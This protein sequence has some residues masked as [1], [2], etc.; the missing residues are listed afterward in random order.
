MSVP[1][2]ILHLSEDLSLVRRP[3][4]GERLSYDPRRRLLDGGSTDEI[5]P[6]WAC[7]CCDHRLGHFLLTGLRGGG[8]ASGEVREAGFD[9]IVGG[10]DQSC[11]SSRKTAPYAE[12]H[13]GIRTVFASSSAQIYEQNCQNDGVLA[14][15]DC[16]RLARIEVGEE[17]PSCGAGI[18]TEPGVS[19]RATV[20]AS[21]RNFPGRSGPGTAYRANLFVIAA[22]ALAG[23]LA[24]PDLRAD[25]S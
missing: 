18:P 23:R 6:A 2:R 17:I 12:R 4:T 20:R 13:A 9:I 14:S 7:F 8:I 10:L 1:P 5:T 16:A 11:G 24:W 3:W 21:D 19:R 15:T 22:G 25:H